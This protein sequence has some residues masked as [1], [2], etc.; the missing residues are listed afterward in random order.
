MPARPATSWKGLAKLGL[1]PTSVAPVL[2]VP[3]GGSSR[4][5]NWASS[6]SRLKYK[7]NPPRTENLCAPD[8][9]VSHPASPEGDHTKPTRGEKWSYFVVAPPMLLQPGSPG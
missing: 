5:C 4:F 1:P 7:P 9:P 8:G 6:E 2:V 3:K